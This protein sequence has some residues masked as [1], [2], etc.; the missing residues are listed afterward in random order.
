MSMKAV[1]KI[2]SLREKANL[3]QAQL[4]VLIGVTPQTIQNWEKGASGINLIE[5][6]IKLCIVLNCSLDNLIEYV[7][8]DETSEKAGA[9]TIDHL[10]ELKRQWNLAAEPSSQDSSVLEEEV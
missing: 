10:R 8:S 6:I 3:T 5:K 4:A 2:S 1:S 7:P 9:F